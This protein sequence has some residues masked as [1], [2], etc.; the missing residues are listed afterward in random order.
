MECVEGD[1]RVSEMGELLRE[2]KQLVKGVLWMHL[3]SGIQWFLWYL[4]LEIGGLDVLPSLCELLFTLLKGAIIS[5]A[6]LC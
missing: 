2:Y 1:L 6:N 4:K 5:E 3:M